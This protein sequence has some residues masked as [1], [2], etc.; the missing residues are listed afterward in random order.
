[1]RTW[2][3]DTEVLMRTVSALFILTRAGLTLLIKLA[4]SVRSV[5][6]SSRIAVASATFLEA[7]STPAVFD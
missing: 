1:M 4:T 3:S 6:M 2:F 5:I 7:V